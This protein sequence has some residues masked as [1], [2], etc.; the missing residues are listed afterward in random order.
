[1]PKIS[2]NID[3]K[4]KSEWQTAAKRAGI[5]LT[6]F[7]LSHVQIQTNEKILLVN[8]VNEKYCQLL[9][10]EL[11]EFYDSDYIANELFIITDEQKKRLNNIGFNLQAYTKFNYVLY[12]K[13]IMAILLSDEH[14]MLHK[15]EILKEYGT[16]E[17]DTLMNFR[18]SEYELGTIEGLKYWDSVISQ[19]KQKH[20]KALAYYNWLNNI[21]H[22][23]L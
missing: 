20:D 4:T 15:F 3:E 23:E 22:I 5:S 17:Y 21:R 13:Q 10:D 2:I 6:D 7:I 8:I 12:A 9:Y 11:I 1:M 16:H 14:I 19:I 18:K